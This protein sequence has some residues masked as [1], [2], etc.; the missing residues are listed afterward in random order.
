MDCVPVQHRG[1][2]VLFDGG[3]V[4][5]KHVRVGY[6]VIILYVHFVGIVDESGGICFMFVLHSYFVTYLVWCV[7]FLQASLLYFL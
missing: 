2:Q 6:T 1:N 4:M 3:T 5:Q 7:E